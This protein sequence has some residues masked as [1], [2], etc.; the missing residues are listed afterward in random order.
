MYNGIRNIK[1]HIAILPVLLSSL[2][3]SLSASTILTFETTNELQSW[4]FNN[5]PEYPGANGS[6]GWGNSTAGSYALL[7]YDFTPAIPRAADFNPKYVGIAHKLSVDIGQ[8]VAR[9]EIDAAWSSPLLELT[10]QYHD[11]TG[12]TFYSHLAPAFES[13]G[14]AWQ[15]FGA[16]IGP[17]DSHWGGAND[18]I[19]HY[20]ITSISLLVTPPT[21][22]PVKGWMKF[23]RITLLSAADIPSIQI[24][25][26]QIQAPAQSLQPIGHYLGVCV[27]DVLN[28][29]GLGLVSQ[30]GLSR[31]RT[32]LS[33]GAV[34]RTPGK[35]DFTHYQAFLSKAKALNLSTDFILCY[36]NQLYSENGGMPPLTPTALEAFTNYANASVA[37]LGT[38]MVSYE[39]WNEPDN[40]VLWNGAPN[41]ADYA[42]L[43][44]TTVTS[45][46]VKFPNAKTV[47]AGLTGPGSNSFIEAMQAVGALQTCDGFGMHLYSGG[48]PEASSPAIAYCQSIAQTESKGRKLYITEWGYSS[49]TLDPA[50][51]GQSAVGRR[52]QACYLVRMAMLCWWH[53]LEGTTFYD[54]RDDG[55]DPT[56]REHNFGFYD[57]N[58]VEKPAGIALGVLTQFANGRTF[59]GMVT[60]PSLPPWIHI[61]CL[62]DAT[63]SLYVLWSEAM[64]TSNLVS[65]QLPNTLVFDLFG[66]Q[67]AAGNQTG[68]FSINLDSN[69]GPVYIKITGAQ[70]P[71]KAKIQISAGAPAG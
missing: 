29:N 53:G 41:A 5:G 60:D 26:A 32:D 66:V 45:L 23:N 71:S 2:A 34:E 54:L 36:G 7:S 46:A 19:V 30:L 58:G 11:K 65:I 68:T 61:A 64:G 44:K 31:V 10:V 67:M 47:S 35:F 18:G 57:F 27:H 20:P 12:Q 28:L 17:S 56:N 25:L 9:I 6:L 24:P 13:V 21:Y 62:K 22:A 39:I 40:A 52:R 69:T 48:T 59:T 43:L 4:A 55:V 15:R 37:S 38:D 3:G 16:E 33:W 51:N 63:T 14:R 50:G 1:K 42:R 70:A 49:V 8:N